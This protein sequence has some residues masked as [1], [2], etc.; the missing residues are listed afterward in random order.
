MALFGNSIAGIRML[1]A[2]AGA[3]KVFLTGLLAWSLGGRRTA[4]VLAM[5]AVIAAPVYLGGGR[6][7]LHEL[8]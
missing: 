3:L 7:S 2:L 4:Q 8:V 6:F 5:V 1:S